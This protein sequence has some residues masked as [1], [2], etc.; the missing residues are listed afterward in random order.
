MTVT[1]L[2]PTSMILISEGIPHV[3][4]LCLD[5]LLSFACTY[6]GQRLIKK[7]MI[8]RRTLLYE[9]QTSCVRRTSEC[10]YSKMLRVA[11]KYKDTFPT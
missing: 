5:N 1:E 8:T 3:L 7:V 9:G 4:S 11:G 6:P 2:N 10:L